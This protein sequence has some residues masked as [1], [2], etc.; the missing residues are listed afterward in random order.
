MP[1][2][3]KK[4]ETRKPGLPAIHKGREQRLAGKWS[5]PTGTVW[6]VVGAGLLASLLIYRF[7]S[8]RDIEGRRTALLAKQRAV[9]ATVGAEWAPLRDRIEK[10]I[11]AKGGDFEGEHVAAEAKSWSA[12]AQP[13]LYLRLRLADAKSADTI[14][15]AAADSARDA[16]TGCMLKTDNAALARGEVDASAFPDQPWNLRQAYAATRILTPEWV[17]EVKDATDLL[18]LRVFEQQYDK[19]EKDEIPRA[20]DIVKRAEFFLLVLDETADD[21]ATAAGSSG[22]RARSETSTG[23][24]TAAA[25]D[26]GVDTAEEQ[27]QLVAHWARV[28][29]LDLQ[30]NVEILRTRQHAAAEFVFAGGKPVT[31]PETLDAMKRQVNN[32]AL[33]Q[34]VHAAI[35]RQ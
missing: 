29:V 12:Q 21:P 24:A 18:R 15:R 10:Y 35:E 13:G 19:A 14:R 6:L 7:V 34:E 33:A 9:E 31:D 4:K 16:F 11:L 3:P 28:Y 2:P 30:K 27:L 1:A 5:R 23:A 17:G 8:D 32:C 20:I 25:D 26:G 22:A